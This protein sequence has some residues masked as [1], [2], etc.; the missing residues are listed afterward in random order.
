MSW[1]P[2]TMDPVNNKAKIYWIYLRKIVINTV[3]GDQFLYIL[4]EVS[5]KYSFDCYSV[6]FLILR[7]LLHGRSLTLYSSL[8]TILALYLLIV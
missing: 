8:W 3:R 7:S 2:V 1:V 6:Y 5:Y 4:L